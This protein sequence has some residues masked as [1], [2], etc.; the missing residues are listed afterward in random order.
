M[1]LDVGPFP[2]EERLAHP[3]L[4]HGFTWV[5]IQVGRKQIG[6]AFVEF[7]QQRQDAFVGEDGLPGGFEE[8]RVTL[9]DRSA[10]GFVEDEFPGVQFEQVGNPAIFKVNEATFCGQADVFDVDVARFDADFFCD[11]AQVVG[12]AFVFD[13][14]FHGGE[15]ERLVDLQLSESL[16]EFGVDAVELVGMLGQ[17]AAFDALL[18][19]A[20]LECRG[21]VEAGRCVVVEFQQLGG[22]GA[23]VGEVHASIQVR[24]AFEP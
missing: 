10:E 18:Q 12:G 21:L 6:V 24:V 22:P 4:W 16:V 23:V 9:G 1:Q 5:G 7:P 3:A 15:V 20:P 11:Q 13:R 8:L 2:R 17:Q 19:P 14:V